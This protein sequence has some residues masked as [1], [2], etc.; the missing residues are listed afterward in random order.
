MQK[1]PEHKIRCTT[2]ILFLFF[3]AWMP[4]AKE[5]AAYGAQAIRERPRILITGGELR[6]GRNILKKCYVEGKPTYDF[7]GV[8]EWCERRAGSKA[9]IDAERA[10]D[11]TD[12]MQVFAFCHLVTVGDTTFGRRAV[13][14]ALG[15]SRMEGV[16]NPSYRWQRLPCALSA[17]FDW[18]RDVMS[19]EEATTLRFDLLKRG[20]YI[21]ERI[22]A[23]SFPYYYASER[24]IAL[25]YIA[26]ALA[27]EEEGD[28][29]ASQW[30]EYCRKVLKERIIPAREKLGGDGGWYQRGFE[31]RTESENIAELLEVWLAG[32]GENYFDGV[33]NGGAGRTTFG[34]LRNASMWLL[35]SMKPDL[36]SWKN[37]D[38]IVER[39]AV[40]SYHLYHLAM[41]YRDGL[42]RWLGDVVFRYESSRPAEKS[43][44]ESASAMLER[45]MRIL[46]KDEGINPLSPVEKGLPLSHFF[47]STGAVFVRSGWDMGVGS[48]DVFGTLVCGPNPS[49]RCHLQQ[50][51]FTISRGGDALAVDSGF[52]D[53]GAEGHLKSYFRET[54]AHNTILANWRGQE[55][56]RAKNRLEW[57]ESPDACR[58]KI[59]AFAERG[60]YMY[61]TGNAPRAYHKKD[62][63]EFTR[64]VIYLYEAGAFVIFD[65]LFSARS[66]FRPVWLLHA[67]HEVQIGGQEKNIEGK[68]G[69][70]VFE[71]RKFENVFVK[72]GG[73]ALWITSH[74]PKEV[75]AR[76]VGGK[77][78]EFYTGGENRVISKEMTASQWDYQEIGRWRVELVPPKAGAQQ[79]FLNVLVPCAAGGGTSGI[80][81]RAAEEDG[82]VWL[83]LAK[84]NLEYVLRF[85][86]IGPAGGGIVIKR[87]GK[88]ILEEK[89]PKENVSFDSR[90]KADKKG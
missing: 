29:R 8:L 33:A 28:A 37:N 49:G 64:Q 15:L 70:G 11:L 85:D 3:F 5:H 75:I 59:T 81:S 17:T 31:N 46:Y 13:E 63:R 7:A 24:I 6:S 86:L 51:S 48:R 76:K 19:K 35:Y 42:A 80:S 53:G 66:D 79:V 23:G 44:S 21:R 52:F 1:E 84:D 20:I 73:S 72:Q 88:V 68:K 74:Y 2:I 30:L 22:N 16:K 18:C 50:N 41:R 56:N 77:G 62:L 26:V 71:Y 65:R 82:M 39:P 40:P 27:G 60:A 61:A 32:T 83:F 45:C 36:S 4:E 78:F 10:D 90:V 14:I 25:T 87:D 12:E 58:G 69:F 9:L 34:F 43:G 89:F 54:I 55:R 38:S 57:I 67:N 47:E